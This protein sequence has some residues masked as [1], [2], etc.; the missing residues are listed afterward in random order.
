MEKTNVF[1]LK[2]I[3]NSIQL[4]LN[5]TKGISEREFLNNQLVKDAVARNFEIIGEA[6]KKLTKE[7]RG[8][9][10][11][12]EWVKMSGMRDKLIHDYFGIDYVIVW[13]TI[14]EILP[15][16][17]QSIAELIKE[18]TDLPPNRGIKH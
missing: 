4:I 9:Y 8:K 10:P 17:D 2:H 6:T 15:N 16:L 5:Y 3:L 11:E 7:F 1:Y 18:E 14:R 12:F 13:D